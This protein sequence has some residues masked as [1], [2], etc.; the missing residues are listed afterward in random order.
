MVETRAGGIA[1]DVLS[2]STVAKSVLASRI[3]LSGNAPE[4]HTNLF[5]PDIDSQGRQ[6][7]QICYCSDLC[8]PIVN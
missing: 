1:Q 3:D 8:R 4:H 2:I 6:C 7:I 5:V